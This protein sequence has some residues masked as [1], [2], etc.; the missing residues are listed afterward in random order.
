M[1]PHESH[2]HKTPLISVCY[3]QNSF[4]SSH[5]DFKPFI[6]KGSLDI[7]CVPPRSQADSSAREEE[8]SILHNT[9]LGLSLRHQVLPLR[10]GAL[11]PT[12]TEHSFK[13]NME[14]VSDTGRGNEGQE[15]PVKAKPFMR[16][17][18]VFNSYFPMVEVS[19][20]TT[21]KSSNGKI[22]HFQNCYR[23]SVCSDK[24]ARSLVLC[25]D[26]TQ[27]DFR[28]NQR[29]VSLLTLGPMSPASPCASGKTARVSYYS[30]NFNH[31][32][33]SVGSAGRGNG[34]QGKW[35]ESYCLTYSKPGRRRA[36]DNT[37]GKDSALAGDETDNKSE[38]ADCFQL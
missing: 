2:F 17:L 20:T 31:E 13:R 11:M 22:K 6:F 14:S 8:L 25:G 26:Q 35:Q 15:R 9:M 19:K 1:Q 27:P 32:G 5:S 21:T 23:T 29:A 12:N 16:Y 18:K 36:Q 33:P 30:S 38:I 10:T 24:A 3:S 34:T 37:I 4:P 7:A 28:I